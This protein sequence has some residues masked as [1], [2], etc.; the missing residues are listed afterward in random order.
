MTTDIV[1]IGSGAGFA[2]DRLEPAIDL[3]NKGSLDFIV[4]ECLAERTIARETLSLSRGLGMGYNPFLEE[5]LEAALPRCEANN[6]KLITNMGA[7]NPIAAGKES[8]NIAKNLGLKDCR[9]AVLIGDDVTSIISQ[10]PGLKLIES[11]KPLETIL[12]KLCAANAYLGADA[13][14]EAIKTEAPTII[15]GRVADPSLF[16]APMLYS[17]GWS[18]ND[19]ELLA[20][21][22]TAGHLLECAGQVTG[23]YFV[24]PKHTDIP[25]LGSLGFP[26]ADVDARGNITISKLPNT[27]GRIDISTCSEQ[28]LYEVSDPSYYITPDCILDITNTQL[29]EIDTNKVMVKGSKSISRTDKY[30]V[31]I[32]Y[33][34]GYIGEGQLSYGGPSAFERAKLADQIVR[35]RLRLCGHNFHELRTDYIGINSLY[36]INNKPK[37]MNEVRLRIAGKSDNKRAA[38]SIGREISA[39]YTNGPAGG[40]GDFSYTKEILAIQSV[41][42]PRNLVI[43]RIEV[44]EIK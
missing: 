15:T 2:G 38:E 36:G 31:S 17:L 37:E 30:K 43:P 40:A 26:Y 5:R 10:L 35:E 39:L 19:Y 12:P 11:N 3:I 33:F 18:Y 1:R 25:N 23:G 9:S 32:G 21:G 41:L 27:G 29:K 16:L 44:I 28:L 20:H 42:L 22:T 6:T 13:I 24:D 14:L 8:S 7:A 34:D 4:F